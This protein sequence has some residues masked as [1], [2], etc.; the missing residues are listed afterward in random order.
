MQSSSGKYYPGLDHVRA[1]AAFLVVTWHF[2]HGETGSPVPFGQAPELGLIDE[3]HV[4][5]ALFMT[6][7][8]YL[9][10]KLIAGRPIHYGA[11]L[12]NRALRL[13]PLISLV[14]LV[15]G[16]L[17]F[18]GKEADY[19]VKIGKGIFLPVLPNGI[20]SVTTEIH[21]YVFLPLLLWVSARWNWAPLALVA[22]ALCI[23]LAILASGANIQDAAYWTIIGRFDQFALGIFFYRRRV[24]VRF[25]LMAGV[26]L[27]SFYAAFDMAGGFYNA[28]DRLWVFIPTI[29]GLTLGALIAWYDANPIRSPRMWLVQKAGEYSFSIYLL[30]FFV[31]FEFA[32]FI[33][34]HIMRLDSLYVAL[35]WSLLFFVA[36]IG[37]GHFSY[38]FIERPPMR[39][40]KPYIKTREPVR[41]PAFAG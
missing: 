17:Y 16:V 37:V 36:M 13:L 35:P 18:R 15:V 23:R 31:V 22:A 3:G 24:T 28:P 33:H 26:A 8:G 7:S 34:Q 29:E 21:F 38:I 25:A 41:V 20:W 9:F 6:L 10:A 1:L 11:F 40:R 32:P 5:V 12:W 30:H 39:F 19:L 4:G 2:T 14:L 27:A